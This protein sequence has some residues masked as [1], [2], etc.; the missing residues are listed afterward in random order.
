VKRF[1]PILVSLAAL[2]LLIPMCIGLAT[3]DSG[4]MGVNIEGPREKEKASESEEVEKDEVVKPPLLVF[5]ELLEEHGSKNF[6]DLRGKIVSGGLTSSFQGYVQKI[7]RR[8]RWVE[9][10]GT[11]LQFC[12]LAFLLLALGPLWVRRRLAG[13]PDR[14]QQALRLVPYFLV[15]TTAVI[16]IT[17]QLVGVIIGLQGAQI[18][19]ATVGSPPIAMTNDLLLYIKFMGADQLSIITAIVGDTETTFAQNPL[20]GLGSMENLLLGVGEIR[21]ASLLG[22]AFVVVGWVSHLSGLYGPA[23]A[24]ATLVLMYTVI[25]P[26]VRELVAYPMRVAQGE[27]EA[28]AG[29]FTKKIFRLLWQ[30]MRAMF[31][32]L[33]KLF[34]VLML[35][36]LCMHLLCFPIVVATLDAL[37]L[38]IVEIHESGSF[39]EVAWFV[40]LISM[41]VFLMVSFVVLMVPMGM[42]VKQAYVVARDKVAK[43]RKFRDYVHLK[44]LNRMIYRRL[45]PRTLLAALVPT[46]LYFVGMKLGGSP[47]FQLWWTS[48][49][50]GLVFLLCLWRLKPLSG[51]WNLYRAAGAREHMMP[52]LVEPVA[53]IVQAAADLGAAT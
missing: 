23:I 28:L 46:V 18:G 21:E 2:A 52:D 49:C 41:A 12:C 33:W 29:A 19:M 5:R 22:S 16:F 11:I 17:S 34:V 20:E 53:E 1:K 10:M 40:T 24:L 50:F 42:S 15:V 45:V 14:N 35:G 4:N 32:G 48:L 3:G 36:V 51:F 7:E 26:I 31:Y 30:E 47:G 37:Q 43:K 9:L 39:D 27:E 25:A 8:F 6:E 13:Q 44:A 38:S